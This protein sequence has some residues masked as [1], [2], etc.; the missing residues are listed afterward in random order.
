MSVLV[1]LQV[2]HHVRLQKSGVALGVVLKIPAAAGGLDCVHE[3]LVRVV[4][5][6]HISW[7]PVDVDRVVDEGR[8]S[9]GC[10]G[11]RVCV[12]TQ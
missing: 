3:G 1:A 2:Q 9:Q 10:S 4:T 11:Q 5:G 12:R 7:Q 8:V 6:Y